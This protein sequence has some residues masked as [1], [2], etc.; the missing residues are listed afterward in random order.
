VNFFTVRG[1]VIIQLK[2]FKFSS[3]FYPN[4]NESTELGHA[5]DS[6]TGY[7][8]TPLGGGK[9]SP[10]VSWIEKSRLE[11]VDISG[12]IPI[13][14]DLAI[15]LRSKT[16]SL[17]DIQAKMREYQRLGVKLGLLINPQGKTVEMY[18]PETEV[19]VL[20]SP[21]SIDCSSVMPNFILNLNKIW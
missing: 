7:D 11:G 14:P 12:F 13:V 2:V 15:E 19:Q 9:L 10:D 1:A 8:F 16:D 5:F 18:P 17:S 3:S 6:S 4:W 21:M 20:E